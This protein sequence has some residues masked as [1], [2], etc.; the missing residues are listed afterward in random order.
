MGFLCVKVAESSKY[1]VP[2]RSD[3]DLSFA[4]A[5]FVVQGIGY[6]YPMASAGAFEL[7]T[8]ARR[9]S[10]SDRFLFVTFAD[11]PCITQNIKRME[12]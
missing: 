6:L 1:L 9:R 12:K 2:I 8:A 11:R 7:A 3:N 10:L 5:S 4:N